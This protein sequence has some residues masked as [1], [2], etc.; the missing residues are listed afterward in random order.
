MTNIPNNIRFT[1]AYSI[2]YRRVVEKLYWNKGTYNKNISVDIRHQARFSLR[3][4]Q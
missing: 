3:H 2:C 1:K 4:E